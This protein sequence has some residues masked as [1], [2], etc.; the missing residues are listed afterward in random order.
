M[1]KSVSVTI[2]EE[3]LS[4]VEMYLGQK[5]TSLETELT[6]Y[7]EQLYLKNVPQN[8]RDFIDMMSE[9]KPAKKPKSSSTSDIPLEPEQ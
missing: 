9:K 7:A 4:A 3:K 8:V 1:K 6:R 5:S 2:S